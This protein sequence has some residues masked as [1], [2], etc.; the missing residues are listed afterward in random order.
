MVKTVPVN[1]D[2]FDIAYSGHSRVIHLVYAPDG[3]QRTLCG[4][5]IP[6]FMDGHTYS[7]I[8]QSGS[9]MEYPRHNGGPWHDLTDAVNHRI[10]CKRCLRVWSKRFR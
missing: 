6:A 8:W 1:E 4:I 3:E 10:N 5:E 7:P 2:D 9:V